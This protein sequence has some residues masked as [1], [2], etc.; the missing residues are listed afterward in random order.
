MA[1]AVPARRDAAL[2][3]LGLVAVGTAYEFYAMR[4]G[5]TLSETFRMVFRTD[6]AVGRL[7]F[8]QCWDRFAAWFPGH[9]LND[10]SKG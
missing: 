10:A 5:T 3:W 6:T 4:G 8:Q 1:P 9:I 7:V 2:V